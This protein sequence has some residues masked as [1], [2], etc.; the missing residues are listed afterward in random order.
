MEETLGIKMGRTGPI[1]KICYLAVNSRW[2]LSELS[3][4]GGDHSE[5]S[6]IVLMSM[7]LVTCGSSG[8]SVDSSLPPVNGFGQL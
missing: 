2:F 6:M 5:T 1:F 8:G 3:F 4:I 7:D